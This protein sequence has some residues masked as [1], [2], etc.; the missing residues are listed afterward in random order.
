[1][2]P[3]FVKKF[4][5]GAALPIAALLGVLAEIKDNKPRTTASISASSSA[6]AENGGTST[7]TVSLSGTVDGA[8]DVTLSFSST[9]TQGSDFSASSTVSIQRDKPRRHSRSHRLMI[10]FM[11]EMRPAQLRLHR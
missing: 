2:Y 10:A 9:A 11:K 8:T 3:E 5:F 6:I 4:N 7:I 1:M